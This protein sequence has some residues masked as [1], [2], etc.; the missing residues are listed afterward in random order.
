V[1]EVSRRGAVPGLAV[2]FLV[3][4]VLFGA[5]MGII[6]ATGHYQ[7]AGWGAVS[8]A[9]AVLGKMCAVAVAEELVFRAVLF[10]IIE[11]WIGTW[12]ALAASA[13]VFGLLHL[14]NPG[15][16]LFGA[17]AIAVEAGVMLG[18][19]Y[20]L[21]RTIWFAVGIHLAWNFVQGGVFGATVS[22][23]ASTFQSLIRGA[24]AGPD[25]LTGG[26]FG[27]EASVP[28]IGVGVVAA[29]VLL[30]LTVRRGRIMPIP[31]RSTAAAPAAASATSPAAEDQPTA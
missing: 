10:R 23:T 5:V 30:I 6:A 7:Y 16:T 11:Q 29:V 24:I 20:A 19:A 21:T 2:G 14:A 22:G 8:G 17:L 13:L 3:G 31:R 9:V 25:L 27:P 28:A 15:A 26:G 1:A 12:L 4:A 18:A